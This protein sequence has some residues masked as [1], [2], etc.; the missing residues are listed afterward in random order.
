MKTMG[1]NCVMSVDEG[2]QAAG[3]DARDMNGV[4]ISI[5]QE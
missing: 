5:G 4:T 2:R 3:F 1:E